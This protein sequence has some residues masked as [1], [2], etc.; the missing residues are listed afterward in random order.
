L[1][2]LPNARHLKSGFLLRLEIASTKTGGHN[3]ASSAI[4]LT[5]LFFTPANAPRPC[6]ESPRF[7]G[8]PC[9]P[10][11]KSRP[12]LSFLSSVTIRRLD[13]TRYPGQADQRSLASLCIF[14]IS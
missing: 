13:S 8:T 11:L 1:F 9:N 10:F 3:A 14:F 12:S 7:I 4:S 2:G 5:R 6:H